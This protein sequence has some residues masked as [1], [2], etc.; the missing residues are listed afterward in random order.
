MV[1]EEARGDG[2][3]RAP[4]GRDPLEARGGGR[5][6]D[7]FE[8]AESSIEREVAL[9]PDVGTTKGHEEIDVRAPP[10]DAL[11]LEER[12]ARRVIF[13]RG[14]HLRI[15]LAAHDRTRQCTNV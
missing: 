13:E 3:P 15:E 7:P 14:E 5:V 8:L 6:S 1:P 4:R 10:A 12:R 11:E 2:P 9:G